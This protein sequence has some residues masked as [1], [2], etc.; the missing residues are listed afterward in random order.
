MYVFK[1]YEEIGE[2]TLIAIKSKKETEI[3][4]IEIAQTSPVAGMHLSSF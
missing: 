3:M 4:W 1:Q 2:Y